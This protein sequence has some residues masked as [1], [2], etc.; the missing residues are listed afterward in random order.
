MVGAWW[1]G[2][3]QQTTEPVA[4]A[5]LNS[6]QLWERLP[7]VGRQGPAQRQALCLSKA[8]ISLFR[9][10]CNSQKWSPARVT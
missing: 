3:G 4:G 1:E 10:Q 9:G 8:G 7:A 5:G 2:K 6:T